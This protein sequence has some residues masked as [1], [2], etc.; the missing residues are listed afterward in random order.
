[1]LRDPDPTD[2]PTTDEARAILA[3]HG[4]TPALGACLAAATARDWSVILLPRP[5]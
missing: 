3:A 2:R 4:V 5:P 1:M